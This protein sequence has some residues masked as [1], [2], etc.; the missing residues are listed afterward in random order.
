M[1][2]D[3]ANMSRE[4]NFDPFISSPGHS[5]IHLFLLLRLGIFSFLHL[6]QQHIQLFTLGVDNRSKATICL[7]HFQLCFNI[8]NTGPRTNILYPHIL[9]ERILLCFFSKHINND[10]VTVDCSPS[11]VDCPFAI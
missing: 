2:T 10:S 3:V 1:D 7:L 5:T 6:L 9:K 4:L 8:S 11:G